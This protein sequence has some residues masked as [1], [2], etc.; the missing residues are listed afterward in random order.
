MARHR[1]IPACRH[2]AVDFIVIQGPV[3]MHPDDSDFRDRITIDQKCPRYEGFQFVGDDRKP[4]WECLAKARDR[5]RRTSPAW[6]WLHKVYNDP[7]LILLSHR[8]VEA[9]QRSLCSLLPKYEN[10]PWPT[11]TKSR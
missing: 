2:Y 5:F 9:W 7:V 4:T 6:D 8:K 1:H 10:R 11:A 3:T